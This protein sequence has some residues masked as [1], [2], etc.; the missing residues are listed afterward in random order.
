LRDLRRLRS[1]SP[2]QRPVG[3]RKSTR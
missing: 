1:T 2:L 3:D